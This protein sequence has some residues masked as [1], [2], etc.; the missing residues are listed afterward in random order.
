MKAYGVNELRTLFLD[1]FEQ[2]GHKKQESFSLIPYQDQSLLLIN[3]GMA[4][5]K[6]YFTG[7]EVPPKRRMVTC[8]KCVR[9][10]DIENVGKTDRHGTFFEMLGNFSFGDYF[11]KEAITWSWEFLTQVIGFDP[12]RLYPSVYEEDEEAYQIWKEEIGIPK[13]RIFRFGKADNFW[14]HGAGPCGPCS[15]IY[16]DRGPAYGCGKETCCVGC[17]CDR[18]IELWN[19]VFTQFENDGKGHYTELE[20]KNIDTGMGLER[21]A[22][23]VQDVASIFDIDTIKQ[24]RDQVCHMAK[25]TYHADEKKDISIRVI[26]DHIRAVTFLMADGVLPSNE[27]RGYVLRRLLRRAARHGK[28]LGISGMFLTELSKTVIATAKDAY[29]LL[30]EKKEYILRLLT[31]EEENFQKTIDQGLRRLEELEQQLIQQKQTT[32]SG[33]IAFQLYDTYGFP[34]DL[35][36]EILEEKGFSVEED[37]FATEMERQRMTAR[38]ARAV[39]NY[40]G[41]EETVYAQITTE[42]TTHFTGYDGLEQTAHVIALTTESSVV[43]RL[44]TGQNG[45]IF[46]DQT[47]FYATMGGQVA[48]HG[49]IQT[50]DAKFQVSDVIAVAGG[51]IAHVGKVISGCFS[52]ADTVHL[53]VDSIRR[54]NITR[55]HTATHLLQKALR[56]VLGSHVAQAGSL[57]EEDHLR[58]DFTHFSALQSQELEAIQR[59]VNQ[60]ISENLPVKTDVMSLEEAKQTGAMA[61]FGEKY[62]EQVRVVT[63][64]EFSKELCG[65]THVEKTGEILFF[66]IQSESGVAAG[67]RRIEARTGQYV[68][69]YYEQIEQILKNSAKQLKTEIQQVPQKIKALLDEREQLQ[70]ENNAAKQKAANELAKTFAD[71]VVFINGCRVIAQK[72]EELDQKQLTVL[73]DQLKQQIQADIVFLAT[74]QQ[75]Q[76]TLLAMATEGAV[77]KGANAGLLMKEIAPLVEGRGGGKKTMAQAGGKNPNGITQAIQAVYQVLEKQLKGE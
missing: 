23:V 29:P 7:Q 66:Q 44:E 64:G 27:G 49:I 10:G 21:L 40:M 41:Q 14:E 16:Y 36:K 3:S 30:E 55:N 61:L 68:L 9:T 50:D 34:L 43:E 12:E 8:Q 69:R 42:G 6:A 24:L 4:P 73:G 22:A 2:K 52:V 76:V 18:Y 20:Q 63:I 74:H 75:N 77:K 11:K 25:T 35:T 72:I 17:E 1:F 70:A 31:I 37:A 58:F 57:V 15:E 71:Q 45:T 59:L 5:L 38:K 47:P 65:G 53:Q 67:V 19:N 28:L 26:T 33:A 39:T 32:L 60:K 56:E 51:K 13:E 48:D 62:K 46:L 54:T